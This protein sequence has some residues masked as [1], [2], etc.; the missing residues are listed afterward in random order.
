MLLYISGKE[1]DS[2]DKLCI[3]S[4][5]WPCKHFLFFPPILKC[6]YV[7]KKPHK[8]ISRH[9]AYF[10]E[11]S[12]AKVRYCQSGLFWDNYIILIILQNKICILLTSQYTSVIV[13]M[14]YYSCDIWILTANCADNCMGLACIHTGLEISSC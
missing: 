10:V 6:L 5:F 3:Y 11:C 14:T 2:S 8:W 7:E 9:L 1:I 4:C 12:L 13:S